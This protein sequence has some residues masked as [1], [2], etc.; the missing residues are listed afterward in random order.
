MTSEH[1][2]ANDRAHVF[3]SL[4]RATRTMNTPTTAVTAGQRYEREEEEVGM[5]G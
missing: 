4:G 5:A 2:F 1:A 3:H